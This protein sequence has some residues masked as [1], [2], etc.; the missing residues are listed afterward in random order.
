MIVE[1]RLKYDA[2]AKV[3]RGRVSRNIS[4]EEIVPIALAEISDADA[5]VAVVSGRSPSL[6]DIEPVPFRSFDGRFFV[7]DPE[8]HLR[9]LM[10]NRTCAGA[11]VGG[12]ASTI[13][14]SFG[15]D[16]IRSLDWSARDETL[17]ALTDKMSRSVIVVDGVVHVEHSPPVLLRESMF[18]Q[19]GSDSDMAR[20]TFPACLWDID[21]E[22]YVQSYRPMFRGRTVEEARL[23]SPRIVRPDLL[24]FDRDRPIAAAYARNLLA[25]PV[26]RMHSSHDTK[27]SLRPEAALRRALSRGASTE[28]IIERAEVLVDLER[29]LDRLPLHYDATL[30]V[31]QRRMTAKS[32]SSLRPSRPMP[33]AS[34]EIGLEW[35]GT[36][37]VAKAGIPFLVTKEAP[38]VA[39]IGRHDQRNGEAD[40][41]DVRHDGE[42][43]LVPLHS[44][45]GL[46]PGGMWPNRAAEPGVVGDMAAAVASAMSRDGFEQRDLFSTCRSPEAGA[47]AL[48]A[49]LTD[50]MVM[51]EGMPHQR[52]D[53]PA[54]LVQNS[55]AMEIVVRGLG[56][57][58]REVEE[59]VAKDQPWTQRVWVSLPDADELP[60]LGKLLDNPDVR[61]RPEP[62]PAIAVTHPEVFGMDFA[63][64]TSAIAAEKT[65]DG[66]DVVALQASTTE[67]TELFF[68]LASE[69]LENPGIA[70]D[71][72]IRER[73][74]R[75]FVGMTDAVSTDPGAYRIRTSP[76]FA[77]LSETLA[78]R[79]EAITENIPSED[80]SDEAIF[81]M[82]I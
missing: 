7:P 20:F 33:V 79:L 10:V 53:E 32:A 43:F 1:T 30:R 11:G 23:L 24:E 22:Q 9:S 64:R 13:H 44:T 15:P 63:V 48:S 14:G 78:P 31:L 2:V 54:I 42:S 49:Y 52:V 8:N 73:Y 77:L 29:R 68:D 21:F 28:E 82:A 25:H 40:V 51:V 67:A 71:P 74:V 55:I 57:M 46:Q 41:I 47:R 27:G 58:K 65:F 66:F 80:T 12:P 75:T 35:N 18:E 17:S 70:E 38:S 59:Q 39:T 61:I 60:I 72:E 56:R 37:L 62:I 26:K 45:E 6:F 3:Q 16:E 50:R 36:R 81:S 76:G 19:W 5:P 4:V 34:M 69:V